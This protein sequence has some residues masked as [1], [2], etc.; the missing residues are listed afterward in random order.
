MMRGDVDSSWPLQFEIASAPPT[1]ILGR[2]QGR[3]V[4][5][6]HPGNY[7][8][9]GVEFDVPVALPILGGKESI[10]Q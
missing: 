9:M 10:T 4:R 5:V 7:N 3:V 2:V 1:Q 8:L 6:T